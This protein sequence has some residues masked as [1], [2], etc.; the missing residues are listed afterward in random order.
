MQPGCNVAHIWSFRWCQTSKFLPRDS[1]RTR[2]CPHNLCVQYRHAPSPKKAKQAA[3]PQKDLSSSEPPHGGALP[4]VEDTLPK[5][6]NTAIYRHANYRSAYFPC[7]GK[8]ERGRCG[9]VGGVTAARPRAKISDQTRC[10]GVW[11]G[12]PRKVYSAWTQ[13]PIHTLSSHHRNKQCRTACAACCKNEGVSSCG[14]EGGGAAD[15]G[16][17]AAAPRCALDSSIVRRLCSGVGA[18]SAA[19]PDPAMPPA[20]DAKPYQLYVLEEQLTVVCLQG[21][22]HANALP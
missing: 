2:S 4:L 8:C 15:A 7:C 22:K 21:T 13:T 3:S 14:R 9:R 11:T 6:W 10:G 18:G 16:D 20:G 17:A 19:A 5:R 12:N 1:S